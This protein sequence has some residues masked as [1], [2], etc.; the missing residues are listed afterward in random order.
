M[1]RRQKE[2]LKEDILK[3]HDKMQKMKRDCE[4]ALQV[5]AYETRALANERDEFYAMSKKL[6][7]ELSAMGKRN[8]AEV[9]NLVSEKCGEFLSNLNQKCE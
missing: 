8:Y 7:T 3:Y 9:K 4:A 6:T 2:E 5:A 1:E